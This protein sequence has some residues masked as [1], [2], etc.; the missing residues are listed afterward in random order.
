MLYTDLDEI[1][2]MEQ[3]LVIISGN[4]IISYFWPLQEKRQQIFQVLPNKE[5][6]N[7][8]T[9]WNTSTNLVWMIIRAVQRASLNRLLK[10]EAHLQLTAVTLNSYS[11]SKE[12]LRFLDSQE[13]TEQTHSNRH[14]H[15]KHLGKHHLI[16]TCERKP[17]RI[18]FE[19]ILEKHIA[20]QTHFER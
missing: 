10:E 3:S 16:R 12:Q 8:K 17:K 7:Q 20:K 4:D 9:Q 2:V 15:K 14:P 11:F 6:K 5:K 13:N 19:M 1:K 18:S